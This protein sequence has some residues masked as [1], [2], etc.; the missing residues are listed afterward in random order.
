MKQFEDFTNELD[1]FNEEIWADEDL[2][3]NKNGI[4]TDLFRYNIEVTSFD[5]AFEN[6][7]SLISIPIDFFEALNHTIKE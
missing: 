5:S 2:P 1:P 3:S 4:F 7:I 6:C